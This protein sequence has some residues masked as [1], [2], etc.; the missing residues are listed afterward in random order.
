MQGTVLGVSN[1]QPMGHVPCPWKV[2]SPGR[3]SS[4]EPQNLQHQLER[5]HDTKN[6]NNK[7]EVC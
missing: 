1:A 5:T 6:N 4:P 3:A 2:Y 7:D